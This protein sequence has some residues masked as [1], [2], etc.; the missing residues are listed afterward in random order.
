MLARRLK[1][2]AVG[3]CVSFCEL[4]LV[5]KQSAN[6]KIK[7]QQRSVS[8]TFII[9]FAYLTYVWYELDEPGISNII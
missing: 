4:I 6:V 8:V 7:N 9:L 1:S 2:E 5:R 3:K